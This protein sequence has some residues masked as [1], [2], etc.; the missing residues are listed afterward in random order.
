MR[1]E[2]AL[3]H[4]RRPQPDMSAFLYSCCGCLHAGVKLVIP[5]QMPRFLL[6]PVQRY[7]RVGEVFSSA[8]GDGILMGTDTGVLHLQPLRH[9][10]H[11]PHTY[12]FPDRMEHPSR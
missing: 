5:G 1:D 7:P 10:R 9:R 4:R 3:T 6:L 8:A 2:L 11:H 12:R